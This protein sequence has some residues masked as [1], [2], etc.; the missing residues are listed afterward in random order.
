MSDASC[1]NNQVEE[2]EEMTLKA[3]LAASLADAKSASPQ[4]AEANRNRVLEE[5]RTLQAVLASSAVDAAVLQPQ[6]FGALVSVGN[7]GPIDLV[8]SDDDGEVVVRS[9]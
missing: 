3:V 5:E 2:E 4:M 8:D 6:R 1:R 9:S 7:D